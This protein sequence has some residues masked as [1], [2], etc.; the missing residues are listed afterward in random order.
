MNHQEQDHMRRLGYVQEEEGQ[1][2]SLRYE[3]SWHESY[4]VALIKN[5]DLTDSARIQYLYLLHQMRTNP[6]GEL[7]ITMPTLEQVETDLGHARATVVR[8]RLLLRLTGWISLIETVRD[9]RGRVRGQIYSLHSEAVALEQRLVRDAT[10]MALL[11]NCQRHADGRLR[12]EA[13]NI[14][15]RIISAVTGKKSEL[16]DDQSSDSELSEAQGSNFELSAAEQGSK[17]EPSIQA[18][19]FLGNESGYPQEKGC[20]VQN[21]NSGSNICSS[22]NINTTTTYSTKASTSDADP[23]LD[24]LRWPALTDNERRLAEL[25]LVRLPPDRRQ[26]VLDA[27]QHQIEQGGRIQNPIAY[28]ARLVQLAREGRLVPVP[29]RWHGE[30]GR[31]G[32]AQ[33]ERR[34][35]YQRLLSEIQGLEELLRLGPNPAL[36]TQL[37][38]YRERLATLRAGEAQPDTG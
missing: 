1:A 17:F 6:Q 19:D 38:R 22:S 24:A 27:Y 2:Q 5:R 33:D 32:P 30:G 9:E 31:P 35:E 15:A 37:A 16:R 12:Q 20:R 28:L 23:G 13:Q 8:D 34:E 4:P 26:A 11:E 18:T 36:E 7:A 14:L 10:Y 3:G 29:A 25:S 21:L